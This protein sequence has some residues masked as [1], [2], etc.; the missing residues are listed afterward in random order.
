MRYYPVKTLFEFSRTEK[1][2][3]IPYILTNSVY[4]WHAHIHNPLLLCTVL[5][6]SAPK[7]SQVGTIMTKKSKH[8]FQNFKLGKKVALYNQIQISE[9]PKNDLIKYL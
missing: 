1:A 8:N 2:G 5:P 9:G 3:L 7:D 6:T 4:Q